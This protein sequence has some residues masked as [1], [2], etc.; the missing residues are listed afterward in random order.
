MIACARG[1]DRTADMIA[2]MVREQD[3]LDSKPGERVEQRGHLLGVGAPG[4]DD[5]DRAGRRTRRGSDHVGV[6]VGSRRERGRSQRKHANP[7][8]YLAETRTIFG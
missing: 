4:I 3:Q 2:V 1:G 5:C 6:G 8:R 7:R